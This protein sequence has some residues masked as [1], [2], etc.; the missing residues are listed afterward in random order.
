MDGSA[1]PRSSSS[2]GAEDPSET[3]PPPIFKVK[4]RR[5]SRRMAPNVLDGH[6]TLA[7]AAAQFAEKRA[8]SI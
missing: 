6:T 5:P 2:N 7:E 4:S 3:I 1:T 8:E